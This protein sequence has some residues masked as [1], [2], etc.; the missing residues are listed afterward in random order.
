MGYTQ[1]MI[2][3]ETTSRPEI[4]EHLGSSGFQP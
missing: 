4:D 1:R 2:M 3:F